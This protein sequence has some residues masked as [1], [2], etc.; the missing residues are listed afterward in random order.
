MSAVPIS[1]TSPDPRIG[2][3]HPGKNGGNKKKTTMQKMEQWIRKNA[4]TLEIG[5]GIILAVIIAI[6]IYRYYSKPALL[7]S[8]M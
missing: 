5:G 2:P 3:T 8:L 6:I 4:K 1:S 7:R